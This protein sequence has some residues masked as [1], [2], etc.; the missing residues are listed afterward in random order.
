MSDRVKKTDDEWSKELTPEQHQVTRRKGTEPAFSGR[1]WDCK[2]PGVYRCV[3]CTVELFHSDAKYDSGTGWPSFTAPVAAERVR[4]EERKIH[5]CELLH[6]EC[7]CLLYRPNT[8]HGGDARHHLPHRSARTRHATSSRPLG[9]LTRR[10]HGCI[11]GRGKEYLAG[12]RVIGEP[13]SVAR[14]GHVV[15]VGRHQRP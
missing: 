8:I 7:T 13:A 9:G 3:C 1:Y 2:D 10:G 15:E 6:S 12:L 11:K 4:T 14:V 5:S